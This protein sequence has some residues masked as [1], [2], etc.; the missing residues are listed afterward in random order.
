M[1]KPIIA[2]VGATGSQGGG[3]V[4]ALLTRGRFAVRALTRD[5]GSE[6]AKALAARGV[7]VVEGDLEDRGSLER[8]FRGARGVFAVTN[9]WEP[10]TGAREIELGRAAVAAAAAAQVSHFVWSTLPDVEAISGG[11]HD[12]AHFTSKAK[13]DDAVT[14]AGFPH[15]T[16]VEAPFYFQNLVGALAPQPAEDGTRAWTLPMDPEKRVIHAGDIHELG[17]LVARVFEEPERVGD[18]QRLALAGSLLSWN[19]VVATL[20]EL[21][22]DVRYRQVPGEVFDGFFPGASELRHMMSYFEDHTYFGP[23]ADRKIALAGQ[24]VPEGFTPFARWAEQNMPS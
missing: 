7:E 11:E 23:E 13:V 10:G 3:V 19:E 18:G 15:H 16:F 24:I 5:P 6:K 1:S 8:A 9:F 2:V 21:G 12:V 4:D 17:A 22:H 20:R 14:A